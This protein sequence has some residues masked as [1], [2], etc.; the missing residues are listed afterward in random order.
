MRSTKSWIYIVIFTIQGLSAST[1]QL[2]FKDV[3]PIVQE[4]MA[5]HVE[6]REMNPTLVRRAVQT[7]IQKFDPFALYFLESEVAVYYQLSDRDAQKIITQYHT[8]KYPYFLGLERSMQSA[9][10]RSRSI[11]AKVRSQLLRQEKLPKVE[12]D[13]GE[14]EFA[15]TAAQLEQNIHRQ[16]ASWLYVYAKSLSVDNL[17]REQKEK[18]LDFYEKKRCEHEDQFIFRGEEREERL[19]AHIIKAMGSSMDAHTM[20]YSPQEADDIRTALHKEFVGVGI[21]F[22]EGLDGPYVAGI[23]PGSPAAGNSEIQVGD[24]LIS[25]DGKDTQALYFQ[26]VLRKLRGP[27][28]KKVTLGLLDKEGHKK[29]VSIRREALVLDDDRIKAEAE[30]F[31]NGYIGKITMTSFYD[32]GRGINVEAD[33][34]QA[35]RQLKQKGHLYGLVI[36]M[37][38]NA[39]GFLQQSIKIAGMFI[40]SGVVVIAKYADDKVQHARD[41][42]PALAFQG[43]IVLLTSKASASAAEIVAQSLKDFGAAVIVGDERTFGKG[44]M[45]IQTI[46]QADTKNHFKVTVGRYYTMSGASPQMEGVVADITVPTEYAP[47]DIGERFLKYPLSR[48]HLNASPQWGEL[49]EIFSYYSHRKASPW[50]KYIPQLQKNSRRRLEK[51][52]NFCAFKDYVNSV[53]S[54]KRDV[55]PF[56]GAEDLQMKES[57]RILQDLILLSERKHLP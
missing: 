21:S 3:Q 23:V 32:N 7:M 27:A 57:V 6:M 14:P 45:Q 44:T 29:L 33:L 9:V 4:M 24:V 41:L 12:L 49:Q 46:T 39:G 37:R 5:Y 10:E 8:H 20:Y 19:C 50:Q 11:R 31:S 17:S 38:K 2:T 22:R 25:V 43:P 34:R 51:D 53:K 48:D 30:P 55:A 36:D 15:L 56:Q 1:A 26:D 47:Y 40:Q 54:G 52:Q 42:N 13:S 28:H 16:M 35:L 18:I